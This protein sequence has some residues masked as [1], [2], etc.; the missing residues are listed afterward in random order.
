[1]PAPFMLQLYLFVKSMSWLLNDSFF[2]LAVINE[3][4]QIPN[5]MGCL[6]GCKMWRPHLTGTLHLHFSYFFLRLS[7]LYIFQP[8]ENW[9]VSEKGKDVAWC[10][11]SAM[12]PC[13]SFSTT[14]NNFYRK[15]G[16]T[17]VHLRTDVSLKVDSTLMVSF[18]DISLP[19]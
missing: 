6:A 4:I 9:Y 13:K 2:N 3:V 14:L 10:G 12:A 15:T 7:I 18:V 11:W 1:M 8:T 16:S 19:F 5:S 17:A